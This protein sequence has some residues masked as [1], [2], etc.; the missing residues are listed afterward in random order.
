M[1][2][3]RWLAAALLGE[4]CRDKAAVDYARELKQMVTTTTG[5]LLPAEYQGPGGT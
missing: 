1:P 4:R 3:E 2:F 5:V